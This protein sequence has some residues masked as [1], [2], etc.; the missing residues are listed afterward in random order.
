MIELKL[1]PYCQ[2]CPKFEPYS[3]KL[4]A[5]EILAD[6]IVSCEHMELCN[7]IEK[8]LKYMMEEKKDERCGNANAERVF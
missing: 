6:T 3:E 7:R 5:D 4:Y 2:S 1:K 8:Y